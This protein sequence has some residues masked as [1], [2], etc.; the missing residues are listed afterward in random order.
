MLTAER[1]WQLPI[2]YSGKTTAFQPGQ[3]LAETRLGRPLR[4]Y[5]IYSHLLPEKQQ[6]AGVPPA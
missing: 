5:P 3:R 1:H 2:A 6:K 4:Q